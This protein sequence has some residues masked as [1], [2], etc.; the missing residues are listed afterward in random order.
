[1]QQL[2]QPLLRRDVVLEVRRKRRIPQLIREA[3]SQAIPRA[4]IIAQSQIASNDVFKQTYA[5]L[6]GELRDH[7]P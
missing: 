3:L 4:W 7:P 5:R 2:H 1:M 6:L